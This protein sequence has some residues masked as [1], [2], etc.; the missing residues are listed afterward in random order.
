MKDMTGGCLCGAIRYQVSGEPSVAG[1]CYCRDCQYISGGAPAYGL[2]VLKGQVRVTQGNPKVFWTQ[3]DSG[4][5]VARHFC[6]DCGTPLF[7][8]NSA[9]PEYLPIKAGSLDDPSSFKC[10]A[11]IWTA[12]AQP[13]HHL[14]PALPRFEKNPE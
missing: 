4:N 2:M 9:N 1:A 5:S 10:Q 3:A 13:W 14:D 8:E 12:S 6:P 11:H 7:S